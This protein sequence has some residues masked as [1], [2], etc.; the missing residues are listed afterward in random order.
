MRR[1]IFLPTGGTPYFVTYCRVMSLI[2]PAGGGS[3]P[4]RTNFFHTM[5]PAL[6]GCQLETMTPSAWPAVTLRLRAIW[7]PRLVITNRTVG[8]AR[9]LSGPGGQASRP[10]PRASRRELTFTNNLRPLRRRDR[11]AR[12]PRRFVRA[13]SFQAWRCSSVRLF[14][15]A[16]R[17]RIS[18]HARRC[19]EVGRFL[20][21]A[22]LPCLL[23]I[24]DP[25]EERIAAPAVLRGHRF[26]HRI[27][28]FP[29]AAGGRR[30]LRP[31][32]PSPTG[33]SPSVQQRNSFARRPQ[34]A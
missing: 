12:P 18:S 33:L 8:A 15:A 1:K 3:R 5:T 34:T 25:S 4:I 28:S 11:A 9:K 21:A 17:A 19:S 2:P 20:R 23:A 26:I 24:V 29:I 10:C 32:A 7:P 22:G 27:M 16:D 31:W 6:Q 30:G 13:A 14:H